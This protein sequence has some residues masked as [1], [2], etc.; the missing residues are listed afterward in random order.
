MRV[1]KGMLVEFLIESDSLQVLSRKR[2]GSL[3]GPHLV[4][5]AEVTFL[6]LHVVFRLPLVDAELQLSLPGRVEVF[7]G[8]NLRQ[9]S[10]LLLLLHELF[11]L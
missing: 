6:P 10:S 7:L 3:L 8:L 1:A 2:T 9:A 4:I 11:I 5:D